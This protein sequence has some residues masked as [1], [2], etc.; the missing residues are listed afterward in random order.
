MDLGLSELTNSDYTP[1]VFRTFST[2]E[3]FGGL[4][5]VM[6]K[7]HSDMTCATGGT[8]SFA[9]KITCDRMYDVQGEA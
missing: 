8:N 3:D 6:I 9:A 7:W 1:K 4:D 2:S 5:G